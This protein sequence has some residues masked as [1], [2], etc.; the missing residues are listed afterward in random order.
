[1]SKPIEQATR[2]ELDLLLRVVD[3]DLT[4]RG[5]PHPRPPLLRARRCTHWGCR[6]LATT[7]RRLFWRDVPVCAEHAGREA[8]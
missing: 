6:E 2:K 4:L 7:R 5:I 3:V 8:S 1:M